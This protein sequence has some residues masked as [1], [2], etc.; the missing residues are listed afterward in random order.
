MPSRA[1]ASSA[2]SWSSPA[3]SIGMCRK[4]A[5]VLL[6][7][8]CHGT[9]FAWCSSSVITTTSPGPR[10]LEPPRV[11]DEVDRLGRAAGED[12]LARRR[13]VHEGGDRAPGAL[14]ALRRALGEPVDAAMDVGVLVLV[15]RPHRGRAPAGASASTRPSRGTR[16]ACRPPARRGRRSRPAALRRRACSGGSRPSRHRSRAG[17]VSRF[18]QRDEAVVR[19]P[20]E[21][22]RDPGADE[23]QH[24]RRL[25][26]APPSSKKRRV[27]G[28]HEQGHVRRRAGCRRGSRPAAPGSRSSP[29]A[30]ARGRGR[31]GSASRSRRCATAGARGRRRSA[32]RGSVVVTPSPAA[33][34]A[35]TAKRPTSRR[36]SS[37][38]HGP[39]LGASARKNAG[40]PTVRAPTTVR[41]RGSSG[42]SVGVIPIATIRNAAK[43]DF[44]TKSFVTRWML[45]RIRRPSATMPGTAAKSP[46]TRT[47]SATAF[48]ICVPEPCAIDEPRR[49]QR[50]HV[51]D[52]VAHH[53]DVAPVPP[54]RLDDAALAL[55]RDPPHDRQRRGE[56]VQ[57]GAVGGERIAVERA[58]PCTGMP[59]S[60]AI[61]PTV[62]AASPESTTTSTPCSSRYAT[63]SRV[64]GRSSSAS[65]ARP[66]ACER[67]RPRVGLLGERRRGGPEADHPA[68]VFLQRSRARRESSR[69]GTARARRGRSACRRC[70]G[71]SSAAGRGTGRSRRPAR[72]WR[73]RPRRRAARVR[74]CASEAA[75]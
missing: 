4:L 43:T 23:H 51:V 19:E 56:R 9:K 32:R 12:D 6:A 15:E 27:A 29:R 45:R 3:S 22:D 25:D 61:E 24:D 5:P 13:G 34:P 48:A 17:Q 54:Q 58:R 26:S 14:E 57:L 1:I 59:A 68:S 74:F 11:R 44:V 71:R 40:M 10:L 39:S 53:R 69:A 21:A 2:S 50:R 28:K 70:A 36:K 8:N 65:T 75:A 66:R 52:A 37:V 20:E 16:A 64:S 33:T 62:A 42:Y 35:G 63:V 67:R 47:T 31:R 55:G 73:D 60:R 18:A 46:S 7:M 72:R 30:R 38:R 49:L 41:W